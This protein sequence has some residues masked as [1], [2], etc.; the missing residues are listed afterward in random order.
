[1]GFSCA[2]AFDVQQITA[3]ADAREM[4]QSRDFTI[5]VPSSKAR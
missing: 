4:T 5:F 2:A 1:M 3:M